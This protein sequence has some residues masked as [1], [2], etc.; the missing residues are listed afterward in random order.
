MKTA[1]EPVPDIHK[2]LIVGDAQADIWAARTINCPSVAVLSG[3]IGPTSRRQL[4]E[5]HPDLLCENILELT[6]LLCS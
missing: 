4:E 5:A 2:V 6:H 1:K 3:A